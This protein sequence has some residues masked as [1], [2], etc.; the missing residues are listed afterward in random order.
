MDNHSPTDLFWL[1]YLY[2]DNSLSAD[3]AARFEDRLAND[4]QARECVARVVELCQVVRTAHATDPVVMTTAE[5]AYDCLVPRG[6]H[7][8]DSRAWL[9]PAAWAALASA[10]CVAVVLAWQTVPGLSHDANLRSSGDLALAWAITRDDMTRDG[11][12]AHNGIAQLDVPVDPVLADPM[13]A[14]AEEPSIDALALDDV[15][16]PFAPSWLLAAVEDEAAQAPI[17]D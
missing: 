3:E 14:E 9:R 2:V 12:I 11:D 1:A 15:S 10:A 5:T 13:L 7:W 16:E 17:A 6:S 8:S 4:Q